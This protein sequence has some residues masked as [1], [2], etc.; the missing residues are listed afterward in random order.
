MCS[1]YDASETYCIYMYYPCLPGTRQLR[2][3]YTHF[4]EPSYFLE[5]K[6]IDV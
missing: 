2:T 4:A 1:T 5:S 6:Y 3:Y